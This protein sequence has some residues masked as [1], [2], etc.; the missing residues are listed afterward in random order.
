MAK[1]KV[2]HSEDACTVLVEGNKYIRAEPSEHM[3][4]FPGGSIAV[5]RTSDDEYWAHIVVNF[6]QVI[7][8]IH[9][10]SKPGKVVRGRIDRLFDGCHSRVQE[11]D[12]PAEINHIAVRI[13]TKEIE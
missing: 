7:D 6:K 2:V 9:E 3:I 13:S 8:C 1:G 4:K 10:Q 5:T 11:I 12:Y